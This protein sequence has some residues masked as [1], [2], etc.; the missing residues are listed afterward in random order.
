MNL[1]DIS[2]VNEFDGDDQDTDDLFAFGKKVKIDLAD[3][4]YES[5]RKEL[6]KDAEVLELLTYMVRDITPEHDLK[7]RELFRVINNKI[8]TPINP[9]NEKIIIFTAFSDTAEYLYNNV[10]PFVKEK[11]GL[12]TAMITGNVEGRT[13]C[14]RLRSDLNTVLT[15]FSPISKDKELLMPGDNTKIDILIA[16]DCIS[17]GQNLQD[18]DYLVNYDI[19]WNPVRIIQRFGRIDR[20]GSRNKVIQ[21]VNFWPDV[22][23]DDYI[24]LK[25][26][27]ETRMKIVDM[28]ATG[29]DNLLSDEEKT[30]LEYRK[31]QLKR[32]QDE[33]V[34]IEDMTTGISIMDLGLNE[35]R[36]DLLEYVKNHPD[37]EK[38]PFGLHS[39]VPAG[40]DAPAGVIFVLKNRSN[41]VNI[42]NQN[43]LHPFYMVYIGDDGEV[44]CNHLSPKRML[45]R[46]R[47]LCKG[48][49][50][51]IPA[52]YKPFNKE[53][54]DG[55]NM[56]TDG[57]ES[58]VKENPLNEN[59]AKKEFQALWREINHKYAYTVEFDSAELIRKAIA[60]IDEKLFVSELQYT[61]TIGRQKANMNEYE[62]DRGDSFTG[63]KTRTQT[64][65]HAETSQI[66]Y[67][68][69]GKI[70]DGAKLTRKSASAILQG[71][72]ADK[73]YMFK[74]NPEE[75]ISKVIRLINEQKA[76]MIVEHIS[77]NTIEGEYDS[78]IFTAEKATQSFDKAFL[79]KKA[80]QDYVFTDGS[81]EKSIERKFAEDLDAAE[82]VCVYAKLPR[83]FQIP[84]PVGNY[85]PDWAIAFY[86]GTVKHIFFV[87]ETKGTMETLELRPI[88]QAKIS[89]AK[90]LFNEMSTS[91]VVYHDV[92]SYQ[93]LLNIMNSI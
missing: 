52:A 48:Q 79:A 39:V 12:N 31:A 25:A 40:E 90:K 56:F 33:V 36:L 26:R 43:R 13:T 42:D 69:I 53:T 54:R 4:D 82:E 24:N 20:I 30:D 5:W 55:K 37:I 35:F 9:G 64:L 27:V 68:L 59:F 21:L 15:C 84:T 19:H 85:S 16:T 70:A 44:V 83:T 81:A 18:C 62:I 63:E 72:R 11:F 32:L 67:D 89:C 49:T 92:D 60:H 80:I 74:N 23:L 51:P 46:M 14:P 88:E 8:T 77:Y 75:F 28:T 50:E 1:P 91:H 61:T 87:A 66:K 71:I 47:F 10:G 41:S 2:N 86:E 78:S 6:Q 73:L 17:E 76:T 7:L 65:K 57:H 29:D 22:T 34:D 93:S 38:T 58:K 45:D 3:M